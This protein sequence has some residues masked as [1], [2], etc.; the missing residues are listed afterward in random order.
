ML[1]RAA[2]AG[3][4]VIVQ[5]LLDAGADILSADWVLCLAFLSIPIYMTENNKH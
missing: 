3:H 2:E 5:V 1:M 4:L